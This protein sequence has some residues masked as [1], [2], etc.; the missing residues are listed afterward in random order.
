MKTVPIPIRLAYDLCKKAY[1][2][3]TLRVNGV[4]C[5]ITLTRGYQIVSFRGTET[6]GLID[7]GGWKDVI[8]DLRAFPWFSSR[9]GGFSHAG[10][11]KGA[12]GIVDKGL[13]GALSRKRPTLLVGHSLGGAIAVNC[14]AILYSE[15]FNIG[16]VITFGSPRTLTKGS[17]GVFKNRG[18]PI[19]QYSNPGDPIPH[20]PFKWWGY[21]HV[22]ELETDRK[23]DGF[24]IS[25]NHSL[26]FY[27]QWID[28]S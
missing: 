25:K 5:L 9:V 10:F 18:I 3:C 4:E 8:R 2:A 16:G 6:D 13:Y 1:S 23:S 15:G 19:D 26:K 22:N 7:Q 24:S 11:F 20:V 21:R 12:R 14:A 17:V 28:R 27:K